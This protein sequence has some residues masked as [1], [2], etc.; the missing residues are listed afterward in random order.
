[1]PFGFE[2]ATR[3]KQMLKK[4]LSFDNWTKLTVFFLWISTLFGKAS[5]YFGLFLGALLIFFGVRVF[6][7]RWYLALTRR[8]D[9]L[10]RFAWALFVSL[11]Y[12]VAQTIYGVV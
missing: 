1:M 2:V 6:W 10:N 7:D 12:G 5:A 4:Y 8:T 9:P 3:E 11:I